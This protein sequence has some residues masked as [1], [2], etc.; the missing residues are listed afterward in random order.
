M[1]TRPR[2]RRGHAYLLHL[3]VSS[4]DYEANETVLALLNKDCI[5]IRLS[6]D[7]AFLFILVIILYNLLAHQHLTEICTC[8]LR[9]GCGQ[10]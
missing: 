5:I 4:C 8:S 6:C 3:C 7:I 9:G 10:S 1:L 2:E